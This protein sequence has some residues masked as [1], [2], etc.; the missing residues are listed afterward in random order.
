MWSYELGAKTRLL[1]NRLQFN[2]A[3]FQIDW[4]NVQTA[5]AAQGCGQN[6]TVNGGTARSKGAEIQAQYRPVRALTLTANVGYN[7]AKYTAAVVGPKPISGA[8][9][10]IF[11]NKGDNLGVPGWQAS[12][13]AQYDFEVFDNR[14]FVRFDYNFTGHQTNGPSFGT[15]NFN[16]FTHN[17]NATS[18]VNFRA[19]MTYRDIDVSVFARNLTDSH[20]AQGNAGNGVAG[21]QITGGTGCTVFN[22]FNPFVAQAYQRPREVGVQANYRF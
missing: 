3:V 7:D 15:G 20:Q 16:P 1:N 5:I 17:V 12:L 10:S 11:F 21:C 22:N 13:A 18:V 6:W 2:V 19:G 8:A 14:S 4:S 9:P